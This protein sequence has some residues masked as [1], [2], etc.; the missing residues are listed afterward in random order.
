MW[1]AVGSQSDKWWRLSVGEANNN[2]LFSS[3]SC[4]REN[5]EGIVYGFEFPGKFK[6]VND[7]CDGKPARV[8]YIVKSGSKEQ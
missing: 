7:F 1:M 6:A 4:A 5:A 8:R 2:Q 3:H